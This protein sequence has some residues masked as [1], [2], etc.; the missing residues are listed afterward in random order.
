M[1]LSP[2]VR[3]VVRQAAFEAFTRR[4]TPEEVFDEV[5]RICREA[6]TPEEV[7]AAGF[8]VGRIT[9][10]GRMVVEAAAA[11]APVP[12]PDPESP[13]PAAE[14]GAPVGDEEPAAAVVSEAQVA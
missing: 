5:V 1:P 7:Q 2:E 4:L 14:T 9:K 10:F 12:T 6:S 8:M 3:E 11:G 13:T